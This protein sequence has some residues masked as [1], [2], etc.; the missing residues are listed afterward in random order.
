M[1]LS[2]VALADEWVPIRPGTDAALMTAMAH[3]IITNNLHDAAFVSSHCV[4]FDASQM[5]DGVKDAESYKDYVLGVRD[6]VPKT[7]QWAEAMTGVPRETTER[8]AREYATRKPGVL[9]Q[10]YG[11]QRR[12]F[13]EQ[14]VAARGACWRR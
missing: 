1:T 12:A 8:L 5:P 14:V 13:G 6:R 4:G 11:M 3:V 7:P 2:A 10:G 9:Y